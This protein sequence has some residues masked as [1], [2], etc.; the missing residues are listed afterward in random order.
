MVEYRRGTQE[1]W[2][3]LAPVQQP[4][5]RDTIQEGWDALVPE[6]QPDAWDTMMDDVERGG[7]VILPHSDEKDLLSKRLA[8]G[9]RAN[10]RGFKVEFRTGL[11]QMAVRRLPEGAIRPLEVEEPLRSHVDPRLRQEQAH[12][13]ARDEAVEGEATLGQ[14]GGR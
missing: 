12:A 1:G 14:M 5:T 13:A 4:D 11:D 10:K 2:D 6:T 8:I 9:R 7:V 3:A